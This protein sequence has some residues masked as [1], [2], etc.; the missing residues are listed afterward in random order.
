MIPDCVRITK[1]DA[2]IEQ[3]AASSS[4]EAMVVV[5]I[6]RVFVVKTGLTVAPMP[7]NVI[8]NMGAVLGH[9]FCLC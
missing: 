9:I 3:L 6:P 2:R 4:M 1:C 5:L 8:Y 7:P